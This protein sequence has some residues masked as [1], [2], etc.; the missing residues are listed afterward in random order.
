MYRNNTNL[1]RRIMTMWLDEY[2]RDEGDIGRIGYAHGDLW[3]NKYEVK[4]KRNDGSDRYSFCIGFIAPRSG[5][6]SNS[7]YKIFIND[8]SNIIISVS[9]KEL[10]VDWNTPLYNISSEDI[11]S[12]AGAVS[13]PDAYI[14]DYNNRYPKFANDSLVLNKYTFKPISREIQLYFTDV[15]IPFPAD[16]DL[17]VGFDVVVDD[18]EYNYLFRVTD[19]IVYRSNG[20][21]CTDYIAKFCGHRVPSEI[22]L[23]QAK[24]GW[25]LRKDLITT[26]IKESGYL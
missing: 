1:M 8:I 20:D 15:D 4:P 11:K 10:I 3:V 6:D 21:W 2:V 25:V 12:L 24:L 14:D 13:D 7:V 17:F 18:I 19:K 23:R 5:A 9:S 26:A 16:D 22:Q